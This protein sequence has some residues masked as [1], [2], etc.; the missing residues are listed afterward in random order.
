MKNKVC[1]LTRDK[2][3]RIR[4]AE[5]ELIVIDTAASL[6]NK[7]RNAFII[8]TAVHE[9]QNIILSQGIILL[10]DARYLEFLKQLEAPLQ[11]VEGRK[12]LTN[13]KPEW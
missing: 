2:R 11:N 1:K 6:V 13:L 5:D 8:D 4:V 9:A 10:D 7:S 3:I 12:R